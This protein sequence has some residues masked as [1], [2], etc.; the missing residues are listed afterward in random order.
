MAM[1]FG[2]RRPKEKLSKRLKESRV[3]YLLMAP[4]MVLF[5]L[6]TVIPVVAAIVLS[7]T[8][9]NMLELPSF[10][11]LMNYERLLL[12]DEVFP[13]VLKNTL[14]FAFLTGPIS[15]LISFFCAWLI[16]EFGPKLRSVF[17]FAFYAPTLTGNLYIIWTYLFSGDQYGI[18]NSTLMN[19]GIIAE[20][21]QWLS[22]PSTVLVVLVIVQLWSSFGVGFLTFIAGFQSNDRSLSEAA[23]IDGVKNRWQELWYV[24]LPSM[25]PQLMFSAVMQI[26]ASFGVVSVI[27]SLAGFPTTQY[28]A[29]TLLTYMLDVGTVRFEMGYAS[30]IAVFLFLMMLLTNF[31]VTH[32]LRRFGTD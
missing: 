23:G 15:Y 18:I 3:A 5:I 26:A 17:T 28:S 24:T 14:L 2:H 31:V 25:A 19:L 21:V 30:A 7:F 8:Y 10:V 11:G 29:D 9:F 16:N 20:P 32:L 1:A 13:I 22:D 27:Q 4:Y 6:L 12:D